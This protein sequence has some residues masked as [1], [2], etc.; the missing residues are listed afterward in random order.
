VTEASI[1]KVRIAAAHDGAAELIVTIVYGNGAVSEI[2]LD[3]HAGA[4]LMENCAATDPE[5]LVG[6]SWTRVKQALVA[7]YNRYNN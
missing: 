2:A 3:G 6:Q 4:I 5:D 7:A 1:Q